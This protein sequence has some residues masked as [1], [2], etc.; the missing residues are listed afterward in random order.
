[1][2]GNKQERARRFEGKL[3]VPYSTVVVYFGK[4]SQRALIIY[5]YITQKSF[6]A[7]MLVVC[8]LRSQKDITFGYMQPNILNFG[9]SYLYKYLDWTHEDGMC[10]FVS[11]ST[12]MILQFYYVLLKYYNKEE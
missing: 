9:Y 3:V 7:E 1:M 5:N 6:N 2:G 10:R 8:S 11:K 12:I 4:F